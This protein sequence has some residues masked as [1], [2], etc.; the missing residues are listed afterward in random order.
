MPFRSFASFATP[1]GF[2]GP[3][4]PYWESDQLRGC[5]SKIHPL[6][7]AQKIILPETLATERLYQG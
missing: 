3:E 5:L 7:F 4:E 1:L 2:I 6:K